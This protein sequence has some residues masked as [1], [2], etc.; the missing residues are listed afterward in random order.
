MRTRNAELSNSNTLLRI[1]NSSIDYE[2][3]IR[4]ARTV[5]YNN[6]NNNFL[7]RVVPI[8]LFNKYKT[9]NEIENIVCDECKITNPYLYTLDAALV[10]LHLL[11]ECLNTT[12]KKKDIV[13]GLLIK[14]MFPENRI[15]LETALEKHDYR[16]NNIFHDTNSMTCSEYFP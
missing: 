10:F 16:Y 15:I 2:S 6:T 11:L 7:L 14:S 9:N 5:N 12:K 8:A 13:K 4:K 1:L 3:A